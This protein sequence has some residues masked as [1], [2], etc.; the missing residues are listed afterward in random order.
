VNVQFCQDRCNPVNCGDGV[1][2]YGR[3]KRDA[4]EEESDR[5]KFDPNLN[6]EILISTTPLRKQVS[7]IFHLLDPQTLQKR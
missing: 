5:I 6:Q 1:L 2:S 4:I 7:F 3:R